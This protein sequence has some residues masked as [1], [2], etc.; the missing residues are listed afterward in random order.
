MA[1]F[2]DTIYLQKIAKIDREDS[3][4]LGYLSSEDSGGQGQGGITVK[5][6]SLSI[7]ITPVFIRDSSCVQVYLRLKLFPMHQTASQMH[8]AY[9]YTNRHE[10]GKKR[11]LAMLRA[12]PKLEVLDHLPKL[13]LR[14][15]STKLHFLS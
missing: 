11:H 14:E 1:I 9:S 3:R 8:A 6:L 7:G 5:L 13:V 12:A 2:E 15:P 4:Y 10:V